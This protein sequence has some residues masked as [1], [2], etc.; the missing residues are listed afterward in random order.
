MPYFETLRKKVAEMVPELQKPETKKKILEALSG[1][2]ETIE[3]KNILGAL[4]KV[5]PEKVKSMLDDLDQTYGTS[6]SALNLALNRVLGSPYFRRGASEQFDRMIVE[7][8]LHA[9]GSYALKEGTSF[10][11]RIDLLLEPEATSISFT[12]SDVGGRVYLVWGKL[13]EF[14]WNH[15]STFSN[16]YEE[17]SIKHIDDDF[18]VGQVDLSDLKATEVT[19]PKL[20]QEIED[21]LSVP[22]PLSQVVPARS[23]RAP[24]APASAA[25]ANATPSDD[26]F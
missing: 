18:I 13:D 4:A 7:Y 21:R 22:G 5:L 11:T 15:V 14:D 3:G 16:K 25:P 20:L 8:A 9:N 19:D 24:A 10:T 2:E 6:V 12:N 26:P 1:V 17:L 23:L